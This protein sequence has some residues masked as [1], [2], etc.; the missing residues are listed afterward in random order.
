MNTRT[1]LI[2]LLLILAL[3]ACTRKAQQPDGMELATRVAQTMAAVPTIPP[4]LTSPPSATPVP[5]STPVPPTE[6]PTP[7]VGPSLTATS[8]ALPAGDPRTGLNL[9]LADYRDDF[10]SRFTWGELASDDAENT[11]ADGRLKAVDSAADHFVWWSTTQQQ[12]DAGDLYVEITADI[13]SC[14]GRDAAG[15]AVRVGGENLDSGYALEFSCDGYYR[16]RKFTTGSVKTLTDWTPSPEIIKGPQASNRMG[17]LGKGSALY[18][19]ANGK[20]LGQSEDNEHLLGNF[21]L[22]SS[23]ENTAGLTVY[24]DDFWLWW[25]K[26]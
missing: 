16:L 14:S 1:L 12:A 21:G 11:W 2:S 10:S 23:A 20:L 8:Q 25:L 15:L 17:F 3:P 6:T 18:S 7:T 5:S 24:F 22:Y 9:S 26:P 19:F 13:E 4:T